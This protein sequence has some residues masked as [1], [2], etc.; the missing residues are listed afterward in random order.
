MLPLSLILL[1]SSLAIAGEISADKLN[2]IPLDTKRE[3]VIAVLGEP[4]FSRSEGLNAEG[5]TVDHLEYHA[6]K[7]VGPPK[8]GD[9]TGQ[10]VMT[11][12]C[13]LTF[14]D[15]KLMRIDRQR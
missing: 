9:D 10:R 3:A 15:G 5:K 2:D 4:D 12:I 11:Y 1:V 6:V 7:R 13:S 14:V 8:I